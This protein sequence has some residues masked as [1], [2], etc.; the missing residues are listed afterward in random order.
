MDRMTSAE[1]AQLTDVLNKM[2]TQTQYWTPQIPPAWSA[3]KSSTAR[4]TSRVTPLAFT[5]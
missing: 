4:A 5:T 3:R 1:E 2:R